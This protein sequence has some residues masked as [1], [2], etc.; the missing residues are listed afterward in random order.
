MIK[1]V[2]VVRK[3]LRMGKGKIGAQCAHASGKVFFDKMI[4]SA[5]Y[6]G[7]DGRTTSQNIISSF[8]EEMLTWL[9]DIPFTKIVVGC[10]SLDE[11]LL[12]EQEC[13]V[14]DIPYALI[15]DNG[16]TEF[17]GQDTITC[18]AVGPAK[19]EDLN[20]ITGKFSLL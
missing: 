15:T 6:E 7:P 13:R 16:V 19:E 12:V 17:H 11:I 18:I 3:D 20:P 14:K 5:V 2:I 4:I 1:Q 8:T 9:K 10:D